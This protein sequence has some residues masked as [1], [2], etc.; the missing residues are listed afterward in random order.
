MFEF[1]CA[2]GIVA[3]SVGAWKQT[4]A[5]A[6]L[7]TAFVAGLYGFVRLLDLSRPRAAVAAPEPARAPVREP[8][9]EQQAEI[10][11]FLNA[12]GPEPVAAEE[13]MPVVEFAEVPEA[14]EPPVSGVSK[15]KPRRKSGSRKPKLVEEAKVVDLPPPEAAEVV[16]VAP[17]EEANGFSVAEEA[18]FAEFT[19]DEVTGPPPIAPLFEPEPFARA[20]R[21]AFGR[22]GRL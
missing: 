5:S 16:D 19:A 3:S 13:A 18:E 7:L 17:L 20:Q 2:L 4:G 10:R 22:R 14:D 6:L 1:L 15:A 9:H 8:V 12:V 11:A 21:R